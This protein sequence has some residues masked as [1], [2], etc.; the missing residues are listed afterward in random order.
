MSEQPLLN[1]SDDRLGKVE[2]APEVIE[3]IAGIAATE[4]DGLYAMRGNFASGVA[5][6]FGKKAH[7]KGVKVE[8]TDNGILI[9]LFVILNF[10]VSIPQVA[11]MLQTNIR[12]TLKNMTALEIDEINVHVVGIQMEGTDDVDE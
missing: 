2:I 7:S 9:D 10:G 12:Q 8:L 4:V 6:R 1:V 3:V 11:Q 5:E